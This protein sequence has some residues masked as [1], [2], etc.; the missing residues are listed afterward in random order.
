MFETPCSVSIDERN[1]DAG[2]TL[3]CQH[4]EQLESAKISF[5]AA[6]V[7]EL[8]HS[9]RFDCF[10]APDE[11]QEE[12]LEA[13]ADAL[14]IQ[15]LAAAHERMTEFLRQGAEIIAARDWHNREASI[16]FAIMEALR[17]GKDWW[18]GQ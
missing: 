18:D 6:R 4:D 16:A 14:T 13:F 10:M 17:S 9:A 7:A 1:H 8:L 11:G 3:R 15:M 2:Y 5:I 12:V